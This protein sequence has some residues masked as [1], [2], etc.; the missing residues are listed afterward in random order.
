MLQH[1]RS[2]QP[3]GCL[4]LKTHVGEKQSWSLVAI[5]VKCPHVVKYLP[6]MIFRHMFSSLGLAKKKE[7]E[8]GFVPWCGC[9]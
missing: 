4:P 2:L 1:R 7:L 6:S 8:G 5:D 9:K 3:D